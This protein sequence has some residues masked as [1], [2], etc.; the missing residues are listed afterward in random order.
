MADRIY[1]V[2]FICTGNSARFILGEGLMNQSGRGRF[3]AYSA[4]SHPK[5]GSIPTAA[6]AAEIRY[7]ADPAS[8]KRNEERKQ[9]AIRD[10]AVTLKRLIELFLSLPL[11][12]L[13]AAAVNKAAHDIGKQ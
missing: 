3:K 10:A 9:Q 5:G 13:D 2:L 1:N 4:G 6:S 8:V 11:E 7:L 12:K